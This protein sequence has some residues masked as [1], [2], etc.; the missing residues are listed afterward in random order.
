MSENKQE[1][2]TQTVVPKDFTYSSGRTQEGSFVAEAA[3]A[4][5][6]GQKD[7]E[8]TLKDYYALPDDIRAELIDGHFIYMDAPTT[9]HQ[10]VI[11]E[12]YFQISSYIRARKGP[13]K[14]LFSP[15]DVRLDN[16]D[17]TMLQP[18]LI[19]LCDEAK[20]DGKQING[21]PD[22]V[23][24]VVSP[25]S[26]KKDYLIKLNKYWNANV[27]EYWII[28]P[29]KQTVST[30]YFDADGDVNV[31]HYTFGEQVPVRIFEDLMIDFTEF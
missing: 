5:N 23:A 12:L 3:A 10:G 7:G 31:T 20:D 17:K 18:D 14:A 26:V 13:C 6:I 1:V 22:F 11:A 29:K 28:D 8:Y 15:L 2:R 24:E 9:R 16:D 25:S 30:Y 21:A 27:R 19:I 4:Y